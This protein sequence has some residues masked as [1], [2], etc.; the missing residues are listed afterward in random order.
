MSRHTPKMTNLCARVFV[1]VCA[2]S[3][4]SDT[5]WPHWLESTRLLYPWKFPG[6]NTGM[7]CHFLLHV[8]FPT[9]GSKLCLLHLLHWQVDSSPQCYLGS[10]H[11]T[12]DL[13][14]GKRSSSTPVES[15]VGDRRVVT[16]TWQWY[17]EQTC[18]CQGGGRT[19][20]ESGVSR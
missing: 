3:V 16:K 20:W 11:T 8:I 10:L 4:V 14:T 18:G 7:D 19:D 2:H 6:K 12:L 5:L 9:Q 1:C 15:M 13:I 17:R